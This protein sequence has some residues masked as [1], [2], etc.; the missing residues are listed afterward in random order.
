[1]K[2]LA[3][4]AR[5][6]ILALLLQGPH[7]GEQLAVLLDLSASTISHHLAR[8]RQAG[9]VRAEA[10]SYYSV[11][12]CEAGA[13]EAIARQLISAETLRRM[14]DTL[15]EDAHARTQPRQMRPRGRKP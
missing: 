10:A 7:T 9:L 5:L 1:L 11:Y 6:N 2:A 12:H 3:D 8:L 14:A 13:L 4:E 15:Y